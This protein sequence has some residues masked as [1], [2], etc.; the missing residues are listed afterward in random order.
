MDTK[1]EVINRA[2]AAL[3]D[4]EKL[5]KIAFAFDDGDMFGVHHNDAVNAIN[6]YS[7]AIADLL[8]LRDEAAE[9][10]RLRKIANLF[11]RL[12]IRR[13]DGSV[14]IAY[15]PAALLEAGEVLKTRAI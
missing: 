4:A 15:D 7:N 6:K 12:V 1:N 14:G 10:E 13:A 5:A 9:I 3:K 11:A 2:I 8:T